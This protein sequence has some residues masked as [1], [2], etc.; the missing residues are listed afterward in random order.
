MSGTHFDGRRF[1]NPGT[2]P[3]RPRFGDLIRWRRER[4]HTAIAEPRRP[5]P[6]ADR[7][8]ARWAA[9]AAQT[10]IMWGG[11]ASF[12]VESAG[13]RCLID[14]VFGRPFGVPE[15]L[16]PSPLEVDQLGVVELVL[17]SHGHYD[18]CDRPSLRALGRRFGSALTVLAPLGL[19]RVVPRRGGV[20]VIELDWWQ[21]VAV[22]GLTATLVP[23][24]HW[25]RRTPWD[26]GR[27]LWGGWVLEGD[28]RLFHCGDSGFF[29]GFAAIGER[30]GPIDLA[31][32]PA[33]GYEPRWFMAPQHMDP[34][35][36]AEA[37]VALG[38][39]HVVP[40][41]WG[42]FL[43]SDEAPDAGP[44][45]LAAALLERGVDGT[46]YHRLAHGGSLGLSGESGRA[47]L[48]RDTIHLA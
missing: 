35:E 17:I 11:H 32:M 44:A 24:Q 38:A 1:F 30:C 15:R 25:H 16:V 2:G 37:V 14:P 42:T 10:R 12:L 5:L 33:G 45:E 28:H 39:R 40:M 6:V 22:G 29:D 27:C 48:C 9:I 23:A 34:G 3:L 41:H 36:C 20:R 47:A 13:T 19:G 18:H 43:L 31:M 4:R 26:F 46:R 7:P 8:F 21:S